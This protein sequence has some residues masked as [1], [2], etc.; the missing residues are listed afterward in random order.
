M[1]IYR[2]KTVATGR[3]NRGNSQFVHGIIKALG[4]KPEIHQNLCGAYCESDLSVVKIY[5]QHQKST[6]NN[7]FA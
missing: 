4:K 2:R 7:Y 1:A 6:V 5:L 3:T